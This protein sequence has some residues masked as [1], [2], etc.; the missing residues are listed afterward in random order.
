MKTYFILIIMLLCAGPIAA[1]EAK[2]R[3]NLYQRV[4]EASKLQQLPIDDVTVLQREIRRLESVIVDLRVELD[5]VKLKN[6]ELQ[7]NGAQ[8]TGLSEEEFFL[9]L[10]DIL[11]Y[12]EEFCVEHNVDIPPEI[13]EYKQLIL[14]ELDALGITA[15]DV[16]GM[17]Q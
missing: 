16:E 8:Q 10:I 1:Q 7:K 6:I 3:P 13:V 15:R 12:F 17:Y 9:A 5:T 4:P 2:D 14:I 11:L